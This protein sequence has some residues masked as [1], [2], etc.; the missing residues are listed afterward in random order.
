M[1]S[2]F[3]AVCN[4]GEKIEPTKYFTFP[5]AV[6][7]FKSQL[8]VTTEFI[9]QPQSEK[10]NH[11]QHQPQPQSQQ[12]LKQIDPQNDLLD[13]KNK[14]EIASILRLLEGDQ[15]NKISQSRHFHHHAP[16]CPNIQ[17]K[18]TFTNIFSFKVNYHNLI[19]LKQ[20]FN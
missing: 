3:E 10:S 1:W 18:Q 15:Q 20:L 13:Q 2:S 19:F 14:Q 17:A 5:S 7:A 6:N 16:Q 11:Q 9:T 4:L 12:I 8:G